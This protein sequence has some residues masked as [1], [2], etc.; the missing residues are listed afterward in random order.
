[1][2]QKNVAIIFAYLLQSGKIPNLEKFLVEVEEQKKQTMKTEKKKSG[3]PKKAAPADVV[4]MKS[5]TE[6][7]LEKAQAWLKVKDETIADLETKLDEAYKEQEDMIAEVNKWVFQVIHHCAEVES[8]TGKITL[9]D[10]DYCADL[11]K[12]ILKYKFVNNLEN[13]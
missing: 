11:I 5:Q 3:R 10:V 13:Y 4:I 6:L 1:M 2:N 7:D 12:R 8:K 9:H